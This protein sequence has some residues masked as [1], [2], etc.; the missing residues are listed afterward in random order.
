[1]AMA[2]AGYTSTSDMS[3]DPQLKPAYEA[4]AAAP[5]CPLRV[6]LLEM[7]TTE[8]YSDT[9]TFTADADMLGKTGVKLWTDGA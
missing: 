9:P 8:T 7:S 2:R 4:L 5:S 3:Y 6:S 1:A